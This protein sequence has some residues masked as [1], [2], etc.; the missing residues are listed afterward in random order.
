MSDSAECVQQSRGHRD[1]ESSDL[2]LV[3]HTTVLGV[4]VAVHQEAIWAEVHE[5]GYDRGLQADVE[6]TT[7]QGEILHQN[8]RHELAAWARRNLFNGAGPA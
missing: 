5:D 3:T 2:P 7:W 8:L 1:I 4:D 6:F